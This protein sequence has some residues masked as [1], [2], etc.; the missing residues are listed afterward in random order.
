[1]EDATE[2]Q[3]AELA[4]FIESLNDDVEVE[5]FIGKQALYPFIISVE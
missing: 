1:G 4:T 3:A 5:L 2:Q